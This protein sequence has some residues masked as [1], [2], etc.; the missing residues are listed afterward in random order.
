MKNISGDAQQKERASQVF[1]DVI[2]NQFVCSFFFFTAD[3]FITNQG[4]KF[5]SDTYLQ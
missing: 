3:T 5:A 1:D 4:D 2:I